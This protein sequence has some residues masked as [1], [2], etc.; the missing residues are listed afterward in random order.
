MSQSTT[1][2]T[3]HTD[4]RNDGWV[5]R[6]APKSWIA[7]LK[8]GRFDRPIGVWLT[9]LPAYLGL[10]LASGGLRLQHIHLYALFFIG[11]FLVRATGCIINDLWDK[12]FDKSV[13][14]TASRPIASGQISPRKATLFLSILAL[15][16]LFVLL[17]LP[18]E[19]IYV[20]CLAIIPISIYPLMKRW[21]YWPQLFLGLAFN[22]S[23]LIGWFTAS[24]DFSMTPFILYFS[25]I[26]ITIGYDTIYGFQDIKDDLKIGVKSTAIKFQN[27]PKKMVGTFYVLG[28][29]TLAFAF[30]ELWWCALPAAL[31]FAWQIRTWRPHEPKSGLRIFKSNTWM[32]LSVLVCLIFGQFI[33]F[34]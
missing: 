18:I 15:L 30:K 16:A 5:D 22:L 26:F 4:I 12:D 20:G 11:G 31:H 2:K 27:T 32:F 23:A 7:Y 25:L 24:P 19:A 14:R 1:D 17:Q 21:T 8:L 28:F 6:Y 3:T 13:E 9:L 33:I 10:I 34:G 29:L